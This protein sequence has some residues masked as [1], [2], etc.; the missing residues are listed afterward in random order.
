MRALLLTLTVLTLAAC[1]VTA[2]STQS[3]SMSVE[4]GDDTARSV[5]GQTLAA[6]RGGTARYHRVEQAL[7]DGYVPA[8]PCVFQT[9]EDDNEVAAMG[10]HYVNFDLIE[11]AMPDDD[12]ATVIDPSAPEILLY[13]PQR[14]G[15]LRLVGVEFMASAAGS[16]GIAPMLD[17]VVFADHT[18][19]ED[20]HDIPFP[21]YDLHVWTWRHNPDGLFASHNP[22][23]SC[24][25][26]PPAD[27]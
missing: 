8:S 5:H 18:A 13:E 23:V 11:G 2:P 9:D 24:Q 7:A 27:A 12:R 19:E 25:Y 21:H 20:R 14:N 4:A 26:A 15:R 1:D 16:D 6:I 10:Y 22:N 17:G 3:A